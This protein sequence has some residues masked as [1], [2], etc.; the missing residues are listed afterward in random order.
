MFKQREV[1]RTAHATNNVGS[2]T[3]NRDTHTNVTHTSTAGVHLTEP[4]EMVS[5]KSV[6]MTV[7][8]DVLR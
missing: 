1:N 8:S 5:N 4:R 6:R 3:S 7:L 2:K